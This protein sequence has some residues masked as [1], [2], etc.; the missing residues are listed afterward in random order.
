MPERFT[1]QVLF[2]T[3]ISEDLMPARS[4]SNLGTLVRKKRGVYK[5]RETATDIG[6]SAATLMRVESGRI[7][8]V[9]TFGNICNWLGVDAGSFFGAQSKETDEPKPTLVS[10]HLKLEATPNSNTLTAL[11]KMIWIASKMQGKTLE[12]DAGEDA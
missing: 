8:D 6:I 9:A 10:A 2:R 3:T 11:S 5:R 4:L 7:P 12:M 1:G